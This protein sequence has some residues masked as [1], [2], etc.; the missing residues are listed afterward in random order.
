MKSLSIVIVTWNGKKFIGECLNSLE[1]YRRNPEAEIIV[2]DNAS[3]D[4]TPEL[5]RD[6]F[7]EVNLIMSKENLGFTRGNNLGIHGCSGKYVCLINPDVKVLDGCIEKML[8][9]MQENPRVGL[10]GPRMICTNGESDRSYMGAPTLWNLFCRA[11]ALD[12]LFPKS[13]MFSGFLMFYFD[14]NKIAEVDILNGWFWMTR[15]EALVEVGLLDET[16][17]MYADDLDWS[18]RFRD[19]GW[20]VVYF[21]EA[22]AIH[23]GGGTT[24]RA[25][26]RFSVEMQK[27]N[28]QYWQ[29]N[30]G[31]VSQIVYLGIAALHQFVRLV[32][33]SILYLSRKSNRAETGF[34]VKRSLACLQWAIGVGGHGRV[35][36]K[37]AIRQEKMSC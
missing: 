22:E 29:K 31:R 2:V 28:F 9:Y 4:G 17:F 13:K 8:A 3:E 19:C 1:N 11:L 37:S 27:A 30:Y 20:K 26:I 18:K 33:Y 16:L 15:R 23:Y 32:S 7:P 35:N 6:L 10:L 14:R 34:K 36:S 5:V 25:P 21:P 24:A 12:V